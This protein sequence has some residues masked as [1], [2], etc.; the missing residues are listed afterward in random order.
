MTVQFVCLRMHS[1]ILNIIFHN[2]KFWI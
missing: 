1:L 2:D